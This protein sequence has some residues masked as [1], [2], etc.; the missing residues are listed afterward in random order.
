MTELDAILNKIEAEAIAEAPDGDTALL[1]LQAV[2]RN[3]RAPLSIRMRAAALALPYESP[4]L[5]VT[6]LLHDEHSF[7][8]ALDRAIQRSNAGKL[9]E[10]APNREAEAVAEME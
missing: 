7:A 10:L 6:A 4:K 9:L 2:Y 3:K 1:L 5:A 8:A